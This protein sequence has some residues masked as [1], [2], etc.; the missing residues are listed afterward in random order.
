MD[1][2][3]QKEL[4][5]LDAE[6]FGGEEPVDVAEAIASLPAVSLEGAVEQIDDPDLAVEAAKMDGQP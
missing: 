2:E 1:P 3:L 4:E 5:G 6:M